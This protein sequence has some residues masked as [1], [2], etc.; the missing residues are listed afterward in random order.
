MSRKYT[1]EKFILR[2]REKHGEKYDYSKI[3]KENIVSARSEVPVICRKCGYEWNPSITGHVN[4]GYNC[5]NCSGRAKWDF[6]KF[7]KE[8]LLKHGNNYDYSNI[9]PID[10]KGADCDLT[11]I[12]KKCNYKWISSPRKHIN[13]GSNCPACTNHIKL[14]LQIFIERALD[15]HGYKYDYS[16]VAE[17]DIQSVYSCVPVTCKICYYDWFPMIGN[18]LNKQSGCPQCAKNAPWTLNRF[19]AAATKING[20]KFDYSGISHI[21]GAFSRINIKCNTC[22]NSWPSTIDSHIS[23][24]NG[25]PHCYGN[26]PW[27]LESFLISARE[28]HHDR[29]DYHKITPEHI[30][31]EKSRIPL[32]CKRCNHEWFTPLYGHICGKTGCP[33]CNMSK[34][35]LTCSDILTSMGITH[36]IQFS[37]RS[38]PNRYY[39][40]MFKYNNILY[41]LEYDGIQH[42]KLVD[43][44]CCDPEEFL[45]K[46]S[47]DVLKTQNALN[48]GYR[49]IR[50]D[51]TQINHVKEHIEKALSSSMMVYFSNEEKYSY[52]S[53][54]IVQPKLLSL[55]VQR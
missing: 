23:Q 27:T 30:K 18:H 32:I 54:K 29:Y 45:E 16:A 43:F 38:L 26:I 22:N 1:L 6:N 50:I 31:G 55:N 24:Q 36:Y 39:D 47:I 52:I 46:Q 19:L 28:I 4:Q 14:T 40:F 11:I 21:K 17:K 7:I 48:E 15:V 35:E 3:K 44:F 10:V 8:A 51:Y 42:F 12:C 25:C 37:I 13:L 2:A 9:N 53:S 41:L 33:K 49:V 5:P 20:A 34:G